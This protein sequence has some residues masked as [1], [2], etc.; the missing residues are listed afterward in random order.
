MRLRPPIC[1]SACNHHGPRVAATPAGTTAD[2]ANVAA[3]PSHLKLRGQAPHGTTT[4]RGPGGHASAFAVATPPLHLPRTALSLS[5]IPTPAI[6]AARTCRR[7]PC[8]LLPAPPSPA[9]ALPSA[10]TGARPPRRPQAG[11]YLPPVPSACRS[12][13][14]P[15][16]ANAPSRVH[17]GHAGPRSLFPT[18]SSTPGCR[19]APR[20]HPTVLLLPSLPLPP[21]WGTSAPGPSVPRPPAN[22]AGGEPSPFHDSPH[23]GPHGPA[24]R[25]ECLPQPAGLGL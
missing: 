17:P 20:S 8:P 18:P 6:R 21:T 23:G 15:R 2:P 19:V 9:S 3:R 22:L 4:T 24:A 5:R 10:A 12:G 16:R 13:A 14:E 11:G 1:R 25:G 7:D